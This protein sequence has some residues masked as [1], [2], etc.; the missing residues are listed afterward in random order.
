[1]EYNTTEA[2]HQA[3]WQSGV[4][5]QM[6]SH[7]SIQPNTAYA[8]SPFWPYSEDAPPDTAIYDLEPS[9]I[10]EYSLSD[11][12][13]HSLNYVEKPVAVLDRKVRRLRNKEIGIV[14]VQWQHRKGSEW[15]WELEAEMREHYPELFSV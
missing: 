6:A 3:N 15:T 5:N 9:T 12:I 10:L 8:P 2:L 1:M 4:M 14:K 13:S 11:Q 7:F